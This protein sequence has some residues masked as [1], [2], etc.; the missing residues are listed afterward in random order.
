MEWQACRKII[1]LQ[2]DAV[3]FIDAPLF[4]RYD[5][6]KF[7]DLKYLNDISIAH[8]VIHKYAPKVIQEDIIRVTLHNQHDLRRNTL[9][10][11]VDGFDE[12]SI[13][14]IVIPTAWN[15]LPDSIRNIS[16]PHLFKKAMKK[17]LLSNYENNYICSRRS[18]YTYN[19]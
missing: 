3:C 16:K 2:K 1:S 9:D 11:V 6:L 12:K 14:K 8:S 5:I 7:H 19:H 15:N 10:L 18:C 17:K 4:K 13:T